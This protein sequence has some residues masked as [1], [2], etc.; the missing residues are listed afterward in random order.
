MVWGV[1]GVVA[2]MAGEPAFGPP[3]EGVSLGLEV[4]DAHTIAVS[5]QNV[6]VEDVDVWSHVH[7]GGEAHHDWT[8]LRITHPSGAVRVARLLDDREIAAPVK[9]HLTPGSAVRHVID[10]D[11]WLTRPVNGGKPLEPARY[12]LTAVYEV[13]IDGAWGGRVSAGPV[14]LA[15]PDANGEVPVYTPTPVY[16]GGDLLGD[17]E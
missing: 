6:G 13:G 7:A 1:L 16:T 8:E 14:E 12:Q 3:S 2:A 15:V 4:V 17:D 9:A 5:L 10:L 11:A